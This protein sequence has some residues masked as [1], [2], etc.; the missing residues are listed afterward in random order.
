MT[1]K[2]ATAKNACKKR[3]NPYRIYSES[4]KSE[5]YKKLNEEYGED[6]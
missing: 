1:N 2:K 3:R 6:L 5:F 4:K